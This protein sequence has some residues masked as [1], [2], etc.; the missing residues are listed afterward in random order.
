MQNKKANK[1]ES[2]I[3]T[4]CSVQAHSIAEKWQQTKIWWPVKRIRAIDVSRKSK[5]WLRRRSSYFVEYWCVKRG[6]K[7]GLGKR[8]GGRGLGTY[9]QLG[10]WLLQLV[11]GFARA[12]PHFSDLWAL[13]ATSDWTTWS[14]HLPTPFLSPLYRITMKSSRSSTCKNSSF[15]VF[16]QALHE[17]QRKA[18]EWRTKEGRNM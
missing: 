12:T 11:I 14:Y 8:T 6:S 4:K 17:H 7:E 18:N 2:N 13:P 15:Q 10:G 16:Q 5:S 3:Y 1:S 9:Q